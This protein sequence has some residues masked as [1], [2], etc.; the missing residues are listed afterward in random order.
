MGGFS[1]GT[2]AIGQATTGTDNPAPTQGGAVVPGPIGFD[3]PIPMDS[4]RII[5]KV[6]KDW[7]PP[8]PRTTPEI[9]VGGKTLA[10]AGRELDKLREWGEGGGSLRSERIGAGTSTN[11]TVNLHG[12]LVYRLPRWTGYAGA[13]AAAKAEWDRML[14]K[15]KAHEDRH[16]EIA[17]E[18][19][20]QLA[21]DLVG[22]EIGEIAG[23]VTEANRRMNKRQQDMD[24][25]TNNGAK[26]GVQ[27]GDV[28]LD[29]SIK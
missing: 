10:E 22:R 15:L 2:L 8:S 26:A 25:D 16:M 21:T 11:L 23:M 28:I 13:S 6:T 19:G 9:V 27:Y 29:T 17:I 12:N 3:D 24:T 18:E 20:N 14:A 1:S 7:D 5:A 4:Q